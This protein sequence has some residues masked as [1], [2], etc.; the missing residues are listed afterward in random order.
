MKTVSFDD[1]DFIMLRALL[2]RAGSYDI[3]QYRAKE[4]ISAVMFAVQR[5]WM[6]GNNTIE[7]KSSK[8]SPRIET[9]KLLTG[10]QLC[11]PELDE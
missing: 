4:L 2:K 11:L 9:R 3:R 1:E 7:V 6:P 8:A 5:G 10:I